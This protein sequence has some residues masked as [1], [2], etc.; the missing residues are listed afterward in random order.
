MPKI[1]GIVKGLGVTMKT[2]GHTVTKG[3]AT[4]QYPKEKEAPQVDA[5]GKLVRV[6]PPKTVQGEGRRFRFLFAKVGP[7]AFLSHLDLIRALPRSFRRIDMPIYYSSGFHPKPDFIFSPALS[8][9]VAS[10]SEVLDVKLIVDANIDADELARE[11]TRVSPPGLVFTRG[12]ALRRHDPS[13]AK[14]I[15]GAR[16]AVAIPKKALEAMGGEA[17]LRAEVERV[18]ATP[19][20]K[21]VR[22]FERGLAKAVDVKRFLRGLE[23]GDARASAFLDEAQVAGD[24]IPLLADVA[25]MGDGG[26]KI[27]EVIEALFPETNAKMGTSAEFNVNAI[28]YHAVRAEMGLSHEGA[29]ITPL[30]LAKVMELRPPPPPKPKPSSPAMVTEIADA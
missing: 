24:F 22:R 18:L 20:I 28:P 4:V 7:M 1:P 3:P 14:V 5:E 8:L 25:I 30:D 27:A 19:E 23:V 13:I 26:V 11:L 10:L 6:R 21:V 29:Y 9:G 12:L 16:Y 2:L 15:D 17:R